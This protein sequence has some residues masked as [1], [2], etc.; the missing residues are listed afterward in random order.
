L[1]RP[2]EPRVL[3]PNPTPGPNPTTSKVPEADD[4]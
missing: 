1:A 3:T 4:S 2:Q